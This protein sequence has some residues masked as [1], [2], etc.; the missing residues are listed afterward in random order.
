M[1]HVGEGAETTEADNAQCTETG[2]GY[3]WHYVPKD[4]C[5]PCI[6]VLDA[7]KQWWIGD[8]VRGIPPL[9]MLDS[10]DLEFLDAIPLSEEE[11]HGQMGPDKNRH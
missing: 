2:Q 5:F 4:W 10:K 3:S 11:Q 7:W 8:S 1:P 6:G 9:R